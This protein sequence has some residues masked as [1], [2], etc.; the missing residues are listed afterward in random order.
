MVPNCFHNIDLINE[1]GNESGS[2]GRL[3][4]IVIINFCNVYVQTVLRLSSQL[5]TQD[6]NNNNKLYLNTGLL[7]MTL[8]HGLYIVFYET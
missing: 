3:V 1:L 8:F 5:Q 4:L 7:S 6:N 2:Y